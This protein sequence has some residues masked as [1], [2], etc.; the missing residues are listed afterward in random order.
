MND[1]IPAEDGE[2]KRRS[3]SDTLARFQPIVPLP[4]QQ[5]QPAARPGAV[6]PA[7]TI[8]EAELPEDAGPQVIPLPP[9]FPERVAAPVVPNLGKASWA[10]VPLPGVASPTRSFPAPES[11][12]EP[13]EPPQPE[14]AR[15]QPDDEPDVM[16]PP[17]P[18][19]DALARPDLAAAAPAAPT[20]Q[21]RRRRLWPWIAVGGLALAAGAVALRLGQVLPVTPPAPHGTSPSGTAAPGITVP[22]VPDAQPAP[23]A[24][25]APGPVAPPEVTPPA[26]APAET[27]AVPSPSVDVPAPFLPATPAPTPEPPAPAP[28]VPAQPAALPEAAPANPLP[29]PLPPPLP[30]PLRIERAVIFYRPD[31]PTAEDAAKRLAE[32]LE[33]IS[34]EVTTQTAT[35]SFR[36]PTIRYFHADDVAGA[37]R[38]AAA[39]SQSGVEWRVAGILTRRSPPQPGTFEVW[40]TR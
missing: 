39:L 27:A 9:A 11:L 40:M 13:A 36:L 8:P 29:L 22:A 16:I 25:A 20:Q 23:D 28:A 17:M 6:P 35:A 4:G 14:P 18:A 12:T 2:P 5:A 34:A 15:W 26:A 37:Q 19:A 24:Q 38:L 32:Q 3:F 21:R 33:M 31:S 30:A 7:P 1:S 10:T